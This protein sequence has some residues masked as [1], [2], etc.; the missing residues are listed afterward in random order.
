VHARTERFPLLSSVDPHGDTIF[1]AGQMRRLAEEIRQL[2]TTEEGSARAE[3]LTAIALLC[4]R[5]QSP[6][7]QYLWFMGD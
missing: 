5:G 3:S 6:P 4:Q 2:L 7:H 1:N